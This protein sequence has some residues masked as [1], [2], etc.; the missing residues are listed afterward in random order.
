MEEKLD[1]IRK[2]LAHA[3]SA[4]A[5]NSPAEA[6]AFAERAR[7]LLDEY[8]LTM[9]DVELH[10]ARNAPIGMER[11]EATDMPPPRW[12]VGLLQ[13]IAEINGCQTLES[14]VDRMYVYVFG[15]EAD[16]KLTINFFEFFL[17]SV[18]G[19][20]DAFR[21][22]CRSGSGYFTTKVMDGHLAAEAY[23]QHQVD[24]Y[25]YGVAAGIH[26]KLT[27]AYGPR[28]GGPE[29]NPN[30][31][32]FVGEK[33]K[34]TAEWIDKHLEVEHDNYNAG[35]LDPFLMNRGARDGMNVAITDKILA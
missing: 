32:V 19:L 33:A 6:E 21:E 26:V 23:C 16:R 13:T 10:E 17:T 1:K 8:N 4:E 24:S 31:L 25:M 34:Q 15:R 7:K 14:G 18:R 28:D 3:A 2:L 20:E 22:L 27:K 35:H 11:V 29:A 30:A 9:D 5:I 12:Q